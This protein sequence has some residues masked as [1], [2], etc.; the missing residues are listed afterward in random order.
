MPYK[1]FPIITNQCKCAPGT[2]SSVPWDVVAPYEKRAMQNHGGQTLEGLAERGGLSPG[3][4]YALI[5][6]SDYY[7]LH[8]KFGLENY[9]ASLWLIEYQRN[10][11]WAETCRL[12]R[13]ASDIFEKNSQGACDL[14]NALTNLYEE[15][16]RYAGD[17]P[18]SKALAD[19]MQGAKPFLPY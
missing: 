3:E 1:L 12:L 13:E 5:T 7:K 10:C 16:V 18:G 2:P 8:N 9:G 4:L 6:D 15:I 17:V 19:A 14:Q 11:K